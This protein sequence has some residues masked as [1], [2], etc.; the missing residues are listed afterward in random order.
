MAKHHRRLI[1]FLTAGVVVTAAAIGT[2]AYIA[3]SSGVR[4]GATDNVRLVDD[5]RPPEQWA[6][7]AAYGRGALS[8]LQVAL[9]GIANDD[10]EEARKG[11]AVAQSLLAGIKLE[12]THPTID[13]SGVPVAAQPGGESG[14]DAALVLIHSEVRV[15]GSAN[16]ANS[17][18]AKLDKIRH[19]VSMTDHHAVI[20]ALESLNTPL[21]YTR[22]DLPL[23]DTIAL[24]DEVLEALDSRDAGR[25]RAKLMEIGDGLRIETVQLGTEAPPVESDYENDA[26]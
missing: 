20:A 9:T 14:P 21:A 22:V 15:L 2:S 7:N 4:D 26:G 12:S 16:P 24:V 25:A 10:T 5:R 17:V 8:S 1:V 11:V 19:D 3:R 6:I 13:T 18:Q 23:A